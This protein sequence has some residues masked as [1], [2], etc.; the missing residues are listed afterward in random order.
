MVSTHSQARSQPN[1]GAYV[2][3]EKEGEADLLEGGT[4]GIVDV[5]VVLHR[6]VGVAVVP[7]GARRRSGGKVV[8]VVVLDVG[9]GLGGER[10]GSPDHLLLR[11]RLQLRRLPVLLP[12]RRLALVSLLLLLEGLERREHVACAELH[13][14]RRAAPP[15]PSHHAPAYRPPRTPTESKSESSPAADLRAGPIE[16]GASSPQG[17]GQDWGLREGW[18]AWALGF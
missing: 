9:P 5:L 17:N 6:L 10:R 14:V 3:N 18:E 12:G 1:H 7:D 13:L 15:A 11:R 4:N 16:A 2:K 8:V